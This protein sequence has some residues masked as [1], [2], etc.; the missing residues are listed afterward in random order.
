[1]VVAE[2][3][4]ARLVAKP[5]AKCT[6]HGELVGGILE[7]DRPTGLRRANLCPWVQRCSFRCGLLRWGSKG[8]EEAGFLDVYRQTVNGLR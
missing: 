2:D 5:G 6:G 7:S 8:T 1:M 3:V 4:R